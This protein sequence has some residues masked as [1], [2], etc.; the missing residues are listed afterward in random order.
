MSSMVL[1]FTAA[2]PVGL[3]PTFSLIFSLA[4]DTTCAT[5]CTKDMLVLALGAEEDD[6]VGGSLEICPIGG[7]IPIC[8]VK[9]SVAACQKFMEL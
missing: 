6:G 7:T 5:L 2:D 8:K 1:M 4:I 9:S 3:I